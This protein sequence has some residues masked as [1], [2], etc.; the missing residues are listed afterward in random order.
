MTLL[1]KDVCTPANTSQEAQKNT[2]LWSPTNHA[3]SCLQAFARAVLCLEHPLTLLLPLPGYTRVSLRRHF[4]CEAFPDPQVQVRC[5]FPCFPSLITAPTHGVLGRQQELVI[6][7]GDSEAD[8]HVRIPAPQLAHCVTL[9]KP[10]DP[11]KCSPLCERGAITAV[12]LGG[13]Q[14][15]S[16]PHQ[17][18]AELYLPFLLPPSLAGLLVQPR[19]WVCLIS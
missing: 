4:L 16:D 8:G 10:L 3:F 7:D 17:T 18:P 9:D 2:F 5:H 12:F 1:T 14:H 13:S 11:S 15:S 6:R 19:T